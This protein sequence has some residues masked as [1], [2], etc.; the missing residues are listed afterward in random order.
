[1]RKWEGG[2]ITNGEDVHCLLDRFSSAST[3]KFC[4]GIDWTHYQQHYFNVIR[5]D[6]KS[7]RCTE[8][9]FYRVDSVNC[10]LWFELP[11]NA[12]LA[13][14]ALGEVLCSACKRL[15]S[16]L[17]WQL[18]RTMSESPSKKIKQQAASSRAKLTY[19]SPGSRMKRSQRAIM[20]RGVDKR[21]L[22]R[23]EATEVALADEQHT[24][25]CSVMDAIDQVAADDL[26][27]IFEEG[28]ALGVGGKLREIWTTDKREQKEEFQKDQAKNVTGKRSNQWSMVT[29][30]MALTIFTRSAAAY[31]ALKS[32]DIL[33]LPSRSLLQSYTGTFL[34]ESGA[35]K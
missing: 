10:K 17:N 33:Q 12:K 4:P 31:E 24:E 30:R 19:M 6:L 11:S 35:S 8:A 14:K 18:E 32:F 27:C 1:M 21:K 25:M 23:Y 7:V 20:E 9:P 15:V 34:H 29:I 26:Q 5:F 16:D 3:C 13:D 22:A 2:F 28:E